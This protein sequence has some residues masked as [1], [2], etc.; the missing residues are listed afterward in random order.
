[1][2]VTQYLGQLERLE[3]HIEYKLKE[4]D[5]LTALATKISSSQGDGMNVQRTRNF[6][7]MGDAVAKIVDLETQINKNIT[8]YIERRDKVI[9]QIDAIENNDFYNI[10]T[11]KYLYGASLQ[12]IADNRGYSLSHTKRLLHNALSDFEER[13]KNEL[14]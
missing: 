5:K 13:Y 9:Q 14:K 1:M 8:G 3:S 4:I 7:K 12:E 6:D 2:N 11:Q 10:L